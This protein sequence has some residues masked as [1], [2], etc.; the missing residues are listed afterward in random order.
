MFMLLTP[1][2]EII[3][4]MQAL[5]K[6]L[7]GLRRIGE[8]FALRSKLPVG[9]NLA[10]PPGALAVMFDQIA[11]AYQDKQTLHDI[12]F[13]LQPGQ[14]LGL[15]GRTG[16][17][18]STLTRLLF[19]FYDPNSGSIQL[20]GVNVRD[21]DLHELHR[22][23]GFVTQEV[24]LVK[25]S[26]RDNLTLFDDTVPDERIFAVLHHLG[27]TAW[28]QTLTS[29]L[30]T[31]ISSQGSSL[32]AGEAQLLAFAR[33]FLKNPDLVVLDEPSS[34]LDPAT[35]RRL[36][37]ALDKLLLGRTVIIIAHR[38]ETVQR[39]DDIMILESGRSVEH[40]SRR[41]LLGQPHS[42]FY[43]L[44]ETGG[45]DLDALANDVKTPSDSVF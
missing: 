29:G 21:I 2:E 1:I 41:T 27:L 17:G 13:T 14:V 30:D 20:S 15:L 18:K 11:F 33:V 43:H 3:E 39:A 44:L 25:G 40:D 24:Q 32:S 7:A 28:M 36:E 38:L 45:L 23:V 5:Q 4:Q 31:E 12:S 16:S 26:L 42:R 6:A 37:Q 9:K 34:R 35:E 19:R 10:L 8:L 22:R